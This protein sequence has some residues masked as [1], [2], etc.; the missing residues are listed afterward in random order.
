MDLCN[1]YASVGSACPNNVT[2]TN[3]VMSFGHPKTAHSLRPY[4]SWNLQFIFHI[5]NLIMAMWN[6]MKRCRLDM[7]HVKRWERGGRAIIG[8]RPPTGE[9]TI[10][11]LTVCDLVAMM[12]I[13]GA[14][15]KQITSISIL[16][17]ILEPFSNG[18]CI[19]ISEWVV[20]WWLLGLCS[21]NCSFQHL[22]SRY[23]VPCL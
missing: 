4:I 21:R 2:L 6:R 1:K 14:S 19:T 7:G 17:G 9:R 15:L 3:L 10:Q 5:W 16:S 18:G 23:G 20:S 22:P 13:A 11:P 8:H 12:S